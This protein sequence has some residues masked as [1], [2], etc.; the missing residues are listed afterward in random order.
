MA[1]PNKPRRVCEMPEYQM[2]GP[3]GRKANTL[4]KIVLLVDEFEV[5]RLMDAEGL[6]QEEAATQMHVARTTVQRIYN[7][8]RKKIADA[9]V[10]GKILLIEGGEYVVCDDNCNDCFKHIRKYKNRHR[11]E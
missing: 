11:G 1:R 4:E 6:T 3:K 5:F 2:F 8:A 9:I 10:N 7:N